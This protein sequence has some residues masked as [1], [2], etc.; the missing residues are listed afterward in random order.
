M[1]VI[2]EL[3]KDAIEFM[4]WIHEAAKEQQHGFSTMRG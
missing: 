2:F 1:F 3:N 4:E